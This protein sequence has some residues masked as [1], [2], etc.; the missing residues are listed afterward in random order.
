MVLALF[1]LRFTAYCVMCIVFAAVRSKGYQVPNFK[2][3]KNK[4]CHAHTASSALTKQYN[5][6]S[7]MKEKDEEDSIISFKSMRNKLDRE[8]V[9]V[10]LPAFVALAADPLASIVDAIYVG[11]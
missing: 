9:G 1:S 7:Y 10:A 8:F 11:R 6:K 3:V 5:K 2:V 4:I